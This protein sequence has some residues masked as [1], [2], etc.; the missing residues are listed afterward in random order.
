MA[1]LKLAV[2]ENRLFIPALTS[3]QQTNGRLTLRISGSAGPDYLIQTSSNLIDWATIYT[4]S[5]PV[6]PFLWTATNT[7]PFQNHYYRVLLAP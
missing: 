5:Q 4:C 1:V 2:S 3:W 6:L 7:P